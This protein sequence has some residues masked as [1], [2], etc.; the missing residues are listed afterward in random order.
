MCISHQPA[1][2]SDTLRLSTH[3]I[4][5]FLSL[6]HRF[7]DIKHQQDREEHRHQPNRY[8]QGQR[9]FHQFFHG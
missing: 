2:S 4:R 6:F 5:S 9:V 8:G 7:T 1:A 3:S